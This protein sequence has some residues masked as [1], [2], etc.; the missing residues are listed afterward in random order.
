MTPTSW[1]WR[2]LAAVAL[3][4]P[5]GWANEAT[6][7]PV[8][9][10]V[11]YTSGIGYFEH[12][13]RVTGDA[14][15]ELRV[16]R[17]HMDDLLQSLRVE[18]A[19]GGRIE[20]IRY[21]TRDP[22]AR[23]LPSYALDL[24][25]APTLAELLEQARG[26]AVRI[27]FVGAQGATNRAE[28]VIVG[29]ERDPS[30]A[31]REARSHLTLSTPAGLRRFDL[32]NTVH[33]AFTRPELQADLD[34]ALDA[35]A[36][37]R[38]DDLAVVG[39]RF[40]GVGERSV[41]FGYVRE[42]PVWKATY[43]LTLDASGDAALQA[44]A[45][46]D[47]ATPQDLDG[48]AMTFVAGQPISF[49]T[50]LYEAV[51]V[52]RPHVAAARNAVPV[53]SADVGVA[54]MAPRA[55]AAAAAPMLAESAKDFFGGG[56]EAVATGEALGASF[57]YRVQEP[58][59]IGRFESAAVPIAVTPIAAE[60]VSW[61]A[62]DASTPHPL[63]TVRLRNDTGLHLA[64]GPV[65]LYDAGGF[66]GQALLPDLIPGDVRML[67]YA[68]DLDVAVRSDHGG[69][70]EEVISATLR[71]GVLESTYRSRVRETLT[72]TLR[73]DTPRTVWLDVAGRPGF[74]VVSPA[75]A[76]AAGDA[77]RFEVRLGDDGAAAHGA[78]P[79]SSCRLEVVQERIEQ[80]T[81]IVTTA[82]SEQLAFLLQNASIDEADRAVLQ[83]WIALQTAIAALERDVTELERAEAAIFRDQERIRANL[84]VIAPGNALHE[85]YLNDL[86][87]QEARLTDLRARAAAGRAE[88]E[89]VIQAR[90][91]LIAR[92]GW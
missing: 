39:I 20:V 5:I 68:V 7:L 37:Y 90:D 3:L 59:S 61:Y 35:I 8:T 49:T 15:I 63:R 79:E 19:S 55:F 73:S 2:L 92:L 31:T 22:L 83:E 13:G 45:I 33:V 89:R 76:I 29:V 23:L 51:Y 57:A 53:A 72:L 30:S 56:V 32:A 21:G 9:Q 64:A 67:G 81:V 60:N 43:R 25:G 10:L 24:S 82:R 50:D 66:A 16:E 78:C 28:G 26:E 12:A 4:G 41:R 75:A 42:M 88:R 77:W 44:W 46:V 65:T 1:C 70:T 87:E 36:R 85:R 18:D 58:V 69:T 27:E 91:A 71:G 74:A 40:A 34:A 11:L 17:A 84:A 48:V 47:N 86:S 52:T 6:S 62:A 38:S 14:L 54:P 80:R